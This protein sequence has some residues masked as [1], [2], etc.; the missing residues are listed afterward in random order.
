LVVHHNRVLGRH[1]GINKTM[2]RL[3]Q[4]YWRPKMAEDVKRHTKSCKKCQE[5]KPGKQE[6]KGKLIPIRVERAWEMIGI[7]I[8]TSLPMTEIGCT[9]LVVVTDYFTRWVEA[10]PTRDTTS[11]T[12]AKLL[13]D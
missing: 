13:I 11:Y 8:I 9:Y 4:T 6:R 3:K 12:I 5:R 10:F 2:E 1:L 7:D